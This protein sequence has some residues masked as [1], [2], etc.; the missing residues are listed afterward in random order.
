VAH[1]ILGMFET[2]MYIFYIDSA[3]QHE[4]EFTSKEPIKLHPKGGGGTDFKPGFE[5]IKKNF[6]DASC[7]LYIT[8][9]YSSSF[10]DQA[11]DIPV[12][13]ILNCEN[14][15]F[16]PPFGEVVRMGQ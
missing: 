14:P 2:K 12:L 1:A 16:K 8:D 10:P 6:Y 7:I 5:H 11:P 15:D 3:F 9:G 13:W 4:E